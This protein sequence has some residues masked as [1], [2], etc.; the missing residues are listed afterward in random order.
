MFL[1]GIKTQEKGALNLKGYIEIAHGYKPL[2]ML[3]STDDNILTAHENEKMLKN[4]YMS[5]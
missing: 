5:I 2:F 4:K 1:N 3:I